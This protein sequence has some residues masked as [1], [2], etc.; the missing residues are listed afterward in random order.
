M[1]L[2][3]LDFRNIRF[4]FWIPILSAWL[5]IPLT[6]L[7]CEQISPTGNLT[8]AS[9]FI[10]M[11]HPFLSI[12]WIVF[13]FR[14]YVDGS[15]REILHMYR[16]SQFL[17]CVFMQMLFLLVTGL[18]YFVLSFFYPNTG[19]EFLRIGVE[20]FCLSSSAYCILFVSR[21]STAAILINLIYV[22]I[23]WSSKFDISRLIGNPENWIVKYDVLSYLNIFSV[24]KEVTAVPKSKFIVT[25]VA[26][27]L[28]LAVGGWKNRNLFTE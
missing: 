24:W 7:L 11:F 8:D 14:Q 4:H 5:F 20:S 13:V 2:Y 21:S 12:W 15:G 25:L 22:A 3:L 28:L 27:L 19:L 1:K 18:P 6:V 16:K 26:G 23:T 10:Q 9:G 17:Q